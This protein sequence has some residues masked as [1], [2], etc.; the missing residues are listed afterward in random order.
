MFRNILYPRRQRSSSIAH[1][2]K[3][4]MSTLMDAHFPVITPRRG[5]CSSERMLK[6]T[7]GADRPLSSARYSMASQLHS[8]PRPLLVCSPITDHCPYDK[9]CP[10][11]CHRKSRTFDRK[12]SAAR[13]MHPRTQA[14]HATNNISEWYTYLPK[15]HVL[16]VEGSGRADEGGD[17]SKLHFDVIGSWG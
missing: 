11:F 8:F 10:E 4:R 5:S 3:S 13:D 16:D 6:E 15:V 17:N 9:S 1:C 12:I 14:L 2:H 7:L